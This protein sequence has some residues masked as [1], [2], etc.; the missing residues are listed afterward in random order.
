MILRCSQ[1][2]IFLDLV[3]FLCKILRLKVSLYVNVKIQMSMF[4]Q[5]HPSHNDTFIN[6][7]F[8]D[9][10]FTWWET[11]PQKRL[12]SHKEELPKGAVWNSPLL[13]QFRRILLFV[14]YFVF[15]S[16]QVLLVTVNTADVNMLFWNKL[17]F[18]KINF[19]NYLAFIQLFQVFIGYKCRFHMYTTCR[20]VS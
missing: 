1:S 6:T 10:C 16:Y 2:N 20:C 19:Y 17:W 15:C 5:R 4:M 7:H 13:S 8:L 18:R 11:Y 12:K 14:W 3:I 9:T